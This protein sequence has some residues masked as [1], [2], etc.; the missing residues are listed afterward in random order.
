MKFAAIG[1]CKMQMFNDGAM[2]SLSL[3]GLTSPPRAPG[4]ITVQCS[5]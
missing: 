1:E 3:S 4:T 2:R 5:G